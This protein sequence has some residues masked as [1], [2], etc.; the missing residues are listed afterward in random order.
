LLLLLFRE[1]GGNKAFTTL[2][3][4]DNGHIG[5]WESAVMIWI[6]F[7][8]SLVGDGILFLKHLNLN[9]SISHGH[10][11]KSSLSSLPDFLCT[12]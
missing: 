7:L 10:H 8:L 9:H 12:S 11:R 1:S 6:F 4:G 5:R 2:A 3:H